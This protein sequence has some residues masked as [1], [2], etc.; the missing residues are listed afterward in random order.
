RSLKLAVALAPRHP[1]ARRGMRR[2]ER[3]S[4]IRAEQPAELSGEVA[5]VLGV[6]DMATRELGNAAAEPPGERDNGQER[7]VS[8]LARVPAAGRHDLVSD[9]GQSAEIGVI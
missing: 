7:H 2:R 4:P 3:S 8:L 6:A 9:G 5:R 1:L